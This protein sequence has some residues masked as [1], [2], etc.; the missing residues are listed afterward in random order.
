MNSSYKTGRGYEV[1]CQSVQMAI[2]IDT[3]GSDSLGTAKL[4]MI[5]GFSEYF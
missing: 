1:V 4:K 3:K 5:V 2:H